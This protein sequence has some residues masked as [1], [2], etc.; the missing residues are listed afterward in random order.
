GYSALGLS[1]NLLGVNGVPTFTEAHP[2]VSVQDHDLRSQFGRANLSLLDRYLFSASLRRDGSSRFGEGQKF[3]I[4]PS[5]SFG[6][7]MLEEPFL[8][9]RLPLS[10][11]KLRASWGKNGNESIGCNYCAY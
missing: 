6:W 4:F 8:R 7:R 5:A 10:D 1:T 9:D 2:G 3:G 11:L